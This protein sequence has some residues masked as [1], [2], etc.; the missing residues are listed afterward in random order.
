LYPTR[1]V[2]WPIWRTSH[3]VTHLSPPAWRG[4]DEWPRA[5]IARQGE[6]EEEVDELFSRDDLATTH[7]VLV[8]QGGRVLVERYGGVQ[9][10]FD[11]PAEPFSS[12]SRFI[13]QSLAKSVLH[14]ILGTLVDE[15]RLDPAQPAPVP[16]WSDL[17]DPRRE[18]RIA[19]MLAMRDGLDFA[20]TT[21][22]AGTATSSR[23]SWRRGERHGGLRGR[24]PLAHEPGT[25]FNY[26]SGTTNLLS[27]IVA[28][29]VGYGDDYV[30]YLQDRLFVPSACAAPSPC[31]IPRQLDRSSWLH[32]TA[33]DFARFGLLYLRGGEWTA[34]D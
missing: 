31:S 27:R 6:L 2:E 13:S 32:A 23:C 18:I 22:S 24:R 15:R 19:D 28:D 9:E 5:T 29:C 7:S 30:S 8:V 33:Q 26:S 10:F 21:R 4:H 16:E 17:G 1:R 3:R 20:R 14:M 34:A 25:C 12:T 11:R